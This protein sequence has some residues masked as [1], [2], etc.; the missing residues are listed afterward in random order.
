MIFG[1]STA[2]SVAN[3]RKKKSGTK[4]VKL[5][6]SQQH[7]RASWTLA[8]KCFVTKEDH[9]QPTKPAKI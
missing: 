8:P 3:L 6:N 2:T 5:D 9:L 1:Y 7:L 4:N